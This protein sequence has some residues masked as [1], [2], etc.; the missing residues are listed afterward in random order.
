[1]WSVK[2]EDV[3]R[4]GM[5]GNLDNGWAAAWVDGCRVGHSMGQSL[6]TSGTWAGIGN[7]C[8]DGEG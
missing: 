2:N 6:E 1:M 4:E 3:G 8:G 5:R 7:C